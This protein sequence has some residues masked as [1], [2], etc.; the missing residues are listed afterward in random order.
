VTNLVACHEKLQI[1][2]VLLAQPRPTVIN[3]LEFL[4]RTDY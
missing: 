4:V 1:S 2:S 3:N